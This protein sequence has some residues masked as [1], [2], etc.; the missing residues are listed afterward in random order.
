MAEAPA[1]G[2]HVD[3]RRD[4]SRMLARWCLSQYPLRRAPT[5][6]PYPKAWVLCSSRASPPADP[7]WVL[8]TSAQ[9]AAERAREP[10][11]KRRRR[12]DGTVQGR[13]TFVKRSSCR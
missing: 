4:V 8:A 3:V 9:R 10:V 13:T 11:E 1:P 7:L 2:A 12:S 5:E 6:I